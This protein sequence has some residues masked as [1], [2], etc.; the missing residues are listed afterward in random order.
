MTLFLSEFKIRVTVAHEKITGDF[1]VRFVDEGVKESGKLSDGFSIGFSSIYELPC[2]L[3]NALAK[4]SPICGLKSC[5]NE[6]NSLQRQ[7]TSFHLRLMLCTMS[8]SGGCVDGSLYEEKS[9]ISWHSRVSKKGKYT[10]SLK[11]CW[12]S[13]PDLVDEFS[14]LPV[15]NFRRVHRLVF[16]GC[17]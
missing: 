12:V 10:L 3:P 4:F 2:R 6:I 13:L 9:S 17:F 11:R 1:Q 16:G 7:L 8:A 14:K 15:G 5:S